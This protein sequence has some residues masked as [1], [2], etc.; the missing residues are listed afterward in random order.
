MYKNGRPSSRPPSQA[1]SFVHCRLYDEASGR[2]LRSY[3]SGPSPVG[4][5][6]DD[7]AAMIRGLLD[8]YEAGGDVAHLQA[9]GIAASS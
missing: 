7:Y 2:L 4:G 1:A 6:A 8:L 9:S 5:F 3:M